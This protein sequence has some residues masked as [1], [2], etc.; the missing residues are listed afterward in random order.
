MEGNNF[1]IRKHLVEYDDVL[2][3][4]RESIYKRRRDILI[5]TEPE[6]LRAQVFGLV[7]QEIAEVVSFH[8]ALEDATKWNVEEIYEV[9]HSI[10]N[11]APVARKKLEHIEAEVSD[12]SED[13][14]ARSKL[15]NYLIGLAKAEYNQVEQRVVAHA[16]AANLPN[17]EHI[18]REAEKTLLLRSID[19]LWIRH[20]TAIDHLRGGIG[21]QGYG[22]RDPLVEYKREGYRM[23]KELLASIQDEVVYNIY[24]TAVVE[25]LANDQSA[26]KRIMQE[27]GP[28][29][30]MAEG[31]SVFAK[32][33]NNSSTSAP[34]K[35]HDAE[36]HKVGRNDPCSC[37]S[38]KKYK[39]CHG[40]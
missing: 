28:A 25:H 32:V 36:G 35:P 7:E 30:T 21:L 29:K 16:T 6:K 17:A 10:F 8:T 37:G 24:K 13:A 1:D 11:I 39:K 31:K 15:T 5:E 20:L 9:V 18:M 38:G 14:M 33:L 23:F 22:Q 19:T 2:N 27:Q 3:K 4:Q 40:A 12:A 26:P 34:A